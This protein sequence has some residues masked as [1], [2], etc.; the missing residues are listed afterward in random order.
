MTAPLGLVPTSRNTLQSLVARL[1]VC[2]HLAL[3]RIDIFHIIIVA[4]PLLPRSL[5]DLWLT[6]LAEDLRI[7]GG[8]VS[9]QSRRSLA[10]QKFNKFPGLSP[11]TVWRSTVP[12]HGPLT[13]LGMSL[14]L[15]LDRRERK[16]QARELPPKRLTFNCTAIS[17]LLLCFRA[18]K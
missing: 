5:A 9:C 18:L 10:L 17:L 12:R 14:S 6:M 7:L 3:P 1:S 2:L 4:S 8:N 13:A 11:F 16:G 15:T